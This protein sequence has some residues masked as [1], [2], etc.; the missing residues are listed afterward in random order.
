M[1]AAGLLRCSAARALRDAAD[2]VSQ[3]AR[4]PARMAPAPAARLDEMIEKRVIR[5]DQI[6]IGEG[7]SSGLAANRKRGGGALRDARTSPIVAT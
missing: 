2:T 4:M 7:T 3:S 1:Q 5:P 6:R